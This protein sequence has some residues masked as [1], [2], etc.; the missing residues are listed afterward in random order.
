MGPVRGVRRHSPRRDEPGRGPVRDRRPG[1]VEEVRMAGVYQYRTQPRRPAVDAGRLWA[2]GVAT[3]LVAALI[4]V[5]GILLARGVLGVAVLARQSA[6][7][8]GDAST[9]WYAAGA[10]LASLAAT[11]LIHVL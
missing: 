10:A 4:A 11:G 1:S 6:G 7:V 5:V 3:A 8:W 2:G 9:G